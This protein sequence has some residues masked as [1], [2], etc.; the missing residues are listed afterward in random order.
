M[1]DDSLSRTGESP[2]KIMKDENSINQQ[3]QPQITLISTD[4]QSEFHNES[5][6]NNMNIVSW[7]KTIEK[8]L[9]S[10][11]TTVIMSIATVYAL[12]G[13]DIMTLGFPKSDD[14]VFSSL[15]V[16]CLFLFTSEL[17]VSFF[18]KFG[19][20]WSFYFWLDLV[21]TLSLIPELE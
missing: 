16:V 7:K 17:I 4:N 6:L 9:D 8:F 5:Q 15:F 20:K 19:Y 12:F 2:A 18:F 13:G 14:V 10:Y 3:G 1:N 21:A 11:T